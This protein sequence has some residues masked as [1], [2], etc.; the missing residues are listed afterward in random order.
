MCFHSICVYM[1]LCSLILVDLPINLHLCGNIHQHILVLEESICQKCGFLVWLL[2][3]YGIQQYSADQG[4]KASK[5]IYTTD[6]IQT[7][8]WPSNLFCIPIIEIVYFCA[9]KVFISTNT[10]SRIQKFFNKNG[11]Q[12]ISQTDDFVQ[13][14][15]MAALHFFS[16]LVFHMVATLTLIQLH[17]NKCKG[18]FTW[19]HVP[20]NYSGTPIQM[21][22]R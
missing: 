20:R 12:A 3:L 5:P 17:L 2:D 8:L 21:C 1:S 9:L 11:A 13:H 22:T 6:Y 15:I 18:G 7:L 14:R 4:A 10:P 16:N 19:D